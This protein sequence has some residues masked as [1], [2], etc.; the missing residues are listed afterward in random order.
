[1]TN[2]ELEEMERDLDRIAELP[3][4]YDQGY[5][6][7][8]WVVRASGDSILAFMASLKSMER[9]NQHPSNKERDRGALAWCQEQL[10]GAAPA[11]DG[12]LA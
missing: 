7:A 6:A 1:M 12:F 8:K 10:D 5:Q 2:E 9:V 3:D 11:N 4:P